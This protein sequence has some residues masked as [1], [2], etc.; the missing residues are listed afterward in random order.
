MSDSQVEKKI[1]QIYDSNHSNSSFTAVIW[2]SISME[3]SADIVTNVK[4]KVF[5]SFKKI[6]LK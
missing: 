1:I 6:M 3:I 2:P 4:G 5:W